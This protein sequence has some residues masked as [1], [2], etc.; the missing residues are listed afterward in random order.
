MLRKYTQHSSKDSG[1]FPL[2]CHSWFPA[3]TWSYKSPITT[4]SK[5]L[6]FTARCCTLRQEKTADMG[7][8]CPAWQGQHLNGEQGLEL[9]ALHT[10]PNVCFTS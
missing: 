8:F 10:D 3:P 5:W 4:T 6:A 9:A 7:M 2:G 1:V